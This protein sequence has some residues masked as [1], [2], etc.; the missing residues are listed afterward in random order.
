MTR[1]DGREPST[2]AQDTL[3]QWQAG[4]NNSLKGRAVF[5]LCPK[6]HL[7]RLHGNFYINQLITGHGALAQY[8]GKFFCKDEICSCGKA[9]ED[10]I[11]LVFHCERWQGLRDKWFPANYSQLSLLQLLQN[12]TVRTALQTIMKQKLEVMLQELPS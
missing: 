8:Q 4:S 7:K 3:Q 5:D 10:R 6:V 12:K 9:V 2:L 11:H 1:L